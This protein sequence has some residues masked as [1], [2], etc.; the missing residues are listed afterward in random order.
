[1]GLILWC[2]VCVCVTTQA[3]H[4]PALSHME[5]GLLLAVIAHKINTASIEPIKINKVHWMKFLFAVPAKH[6]LVM[7]P[8][9]PSSWIHGWKSIR[10]ELLVLLMN[11]CSSPGVSMWA[12]AAG[13]IVSRIQMNC[14]KWWNTGRVPNH[15]QALLKYQ[16]QYMQL[17]AVGGRKVQ[18]VL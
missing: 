5:P 6:H 12:R 18:L 11:K 4:V 8:S 13:Q 3:A 15:L 7:S 9:M 14:V 16:V 10:T 17:C 1:M 2:S